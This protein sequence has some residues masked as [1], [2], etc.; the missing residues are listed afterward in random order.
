MQ[1]KL[2]EPKGFK[3]HRIE[4]DKPASRDDGI[5]IHQILFLFVALIALLIPFSQFTLVPTEVERTMRPSNRI[6]GSRTVRKE[7]A[8]GFDQTRHEALIL[9]P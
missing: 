9:L 4:I 7:Y 5:N 2:C 8:N 1:H 3:F 6:A